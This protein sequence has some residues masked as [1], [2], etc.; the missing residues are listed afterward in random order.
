MTSV[1]TAIIYIEGAFPEVGNEKADHVEPA[2]ARRLIRG[3]QGPFG[4]R[5]FGVQTRGPGGKINHAA[6]KLGDAVVMMG[7][8]ASG[9]R[10]PKR[11]GQATQSLYVTVNDVD[12]HFERARRAGAVIIEEPADTSYGHRR[13][14]DGPRR[15]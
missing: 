8:P 4:F 15:P 1:Y 11:L 2:Y 5:R 14:G 6:M 12:K 7:R 9:Y 13:Y 10:N 3:R